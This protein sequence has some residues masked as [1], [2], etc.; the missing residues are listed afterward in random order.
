MSETTIKKGHPKALYILFFTE[1]W[2][3]FGYY[4]MVG[5]FLL[6]LIDPT[7]SGGKAFSNANAADLVGSFIA[8]VYLTPF[9]GG[10]IADRYLGYRKSILLG[11]S[12]MAAGYLGLSLPGDTAMYFS[13]LC[14]ITGN[15][16]FKPNISTLLG[17]IYSEQDLK[18]KKD[19]AY[20]IFYMGINIGAFFCNFVA[21][22]LRNYYGWGYA[23]AAAGVGMII[24]LIIFGSNFK[25]EHIANGD[26]LKPL[27]KEDMAISKIMMYVF[28][29]AILA[30]TLGWYFSSIIGH[31]LFGTNSNDAFM[32]ACVPIIVFYAGLLIR[33]SK[34]DKRG[35]G[36]LMAFFIVSIV[37]WVIYNQNST[38][39]TI[40]AQTYTD[41]KMPESGVAFTK[42][43]GMLQT[44]TTDTVEI[45]K[46]DERFKPILDEDGNTIPVAGVDPYLQNLPKD[47]WPAKGEE[48]KLLS[49][50]LFQSV[51]PFFIVLFT[52]LIAVWLFGWLRRRKKEPS[53]PAKIGIGMVLAGLSSLLMFGAVMSND[54]Y[55]E[56]TNMLWLISTYAI[57]TIGELLIS[58][59]GLSMVSKLSPPR[60]TALMMGAWFL[61]NSIAGKISGLMATFWD[62]FP[63]K[64][65]YFLILFV[66]A[67]VAA[68]ILFS[69]VKWLRA[70]VR[71]KTGS[72]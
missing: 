48:M 13:L 59:I 26:V 54:I 10:L 16:F 45:T 64:Q 21:A 68:V 71:E 47:Q 17:N 20:G 43:F 12:L 53:T 15:G 3:R 55:V 40:W 38:A 63:Q 31:T 35:L 56:K 25:D 22:Y 27:Q 14:I 7:A 9:I 41:R 37:F 44:V 69:M 50:E 23:F 52:P 42:P 65:N 46:V 70:V 8:L 30:G 29:P 62:Q 58:P 6:Y 36:A 28:V 39:L 49:P 18:P 72:D 51:N 19:A 66:A 1:M 32:F 57:F 60:L 4:L 2:E 34:E 5:I 33:A 24:A 67:M 11:G 61:I